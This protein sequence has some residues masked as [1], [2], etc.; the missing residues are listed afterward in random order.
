VHEQ[1]LI[2]AHRGASGYLPEHTLEAKALAYG[3]G[4]DYLEQDVVATRDDRLVV[5]HD[6][7]LD[8]VTD[9]AVRFPERHRPDGRFYARDFD[10][11]ELTTLNVHERRS[12]AGEAVYP[13]RF[14]AD[15]GR[16][17][18]ATI[19]EEIELLHGL[20]TSTG[21]SVGI[22]PEVKRPAWHRT[23][24]IDVAERLLRVLDGYGYRNRADPVYLQCFDADELRRIREDLDCDLKLIQLI[25][26]NAW[27]ESDTDYD[28]LRSPRGLKRLA[29]LVDGIGPSIEQLYTLAAIDGQPISTGLASEAHKR[30]LAVHAY[31]FRADAL[32]HGFASFAEMVAWFVDSLA[33][34]GLFTDFPDLARQAVAGIRPVSAKIL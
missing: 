2:I 11:A 3:L 28:A 29:G 5:L 4:A 1:P 25:G 33:V 24:G 15:I 18:V 22:Y 20:N 10:L 6:I 7:H 17:T 23:E 21:R 14:P 26:E 12:E 30:G 9:V 13:R 34:D 27:R 8:R 31:T 19:E 16:F 32:A